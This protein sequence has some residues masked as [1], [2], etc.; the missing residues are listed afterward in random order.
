MGGCSCEWN[1]LV[2]LSG[3]R[4]GQVTLWKTKRPGS[5]LHPPGKC[6]VRSLLPSHTICVSGDRTPETVRRAGLICLLQ[7]N[8]GPTWR[9]EEKQGPNQVRRVRRRERS[10]DIWESWRAQLLALARQGWA[11]C[12]A[13]SQHPLTCSPGPCKVLWSTFPH[14]EQR[15]LHSLLFVFFFREVA[16]AKPSAS[17]ILS[18]PEPTQLLLL[19]CCQ[20]D[21]FTPIQQPGLT[22]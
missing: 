11:L 9:L 18:Q 19:A 3:Q 4:Q 22:H 13:S 7:Q 1:F 15:Q 20:C 21:S 17:D 8:T 6:P 16:G 12:R 14:S 5:H 10:I 2:C